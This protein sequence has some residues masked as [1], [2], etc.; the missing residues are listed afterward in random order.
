MGL[1]IWQGAGRLTWGKRITLKNYFPCIWQ[2]GMS[3]RWRKAILQYQKGTFPIVLIAHCW[4]HALTSPSSLAPKQGELCSR[5]E[6]PQIISLYQSWGAGDTRLVVQHPDSQGGHPSLQGDG[7][8]EGPGTDEAEHA[9]A[10]R[11]GANKN[12]NSLVDCFSERC[13]IV[14]IY[15]EIWVL[16]NC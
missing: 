15:M 10:F 13:K 3:C 5:A 7:S 14:N 11:K 6:E 8:G 4:Q 9:S 2:V 16:N 12:E 1:Y